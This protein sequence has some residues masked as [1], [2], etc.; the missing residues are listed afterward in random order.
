MKLCWWTDYPTENQRLLIAE[1]RKKEVDI[2]ICYFRRYDDY[3]KAMGWKDES[4]QEG[5]FFAPTLSAASAQIKDFDTRIQVVPSYADLISWKLILRSVFL[6]RPWIAALERSRGRFRS[7]VFRKL[8]AVF[9]DRF[10]IAVFC[11]GNEAVEQYAALGIKREKL[12]WTAYAMRDRGLAAH[13]DL[14]ISK[15]GVRF[16][17][18]GALVERKAV[19]VLARAFAC[20][21]KKNPDSLLRIAGDGDL[22]SVFENLEGVEIVGALEPD[23]VFQI[24]R[25][26]DVIVLPSRYDAWGVALVEGG[27]AGLAMI[28]S[29][30]TGASEL[31][32]EDEQNGMVVRAGSVDSLAQAMLKYAVNPELVFEHGCAARISAEKTLASSLAYKMSKQLVGKMGAI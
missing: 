16:L 3:R 7:W 10:A 5:E 32:S 11:V 8:F 19:D 29:D 9:A 23:K 30:A 31:I 25:E 21:K 15:R 4:L 26:C 28:G 17:F 2:V 20:V 1:L 12:F 24:M 22:K 18:A 13:S 27:L 6:G 14:A